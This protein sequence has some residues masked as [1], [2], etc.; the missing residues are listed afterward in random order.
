MGTAVVVGVVV[1]EVVVAAAAQVQR[2]MRKLGGK[3]NE[4]DENTFIDFFASLLLA[5][6]VT[7]FSG[8]WAVLGS[9]GLVWVSS[10]KNNAHSVTK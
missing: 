10:D 6:L 3:I 9:S 8:L 7:H 5:L 1:V 4:E 2:R